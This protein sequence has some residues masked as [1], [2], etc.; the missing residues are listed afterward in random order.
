MLITARAGHGPAHSRGVIGHARST[1]LLSW[2]VRPPL[3]APATFGHLEVPQVTLIDGHPCL[4]FCTYSL[5]PTHGKSPSRIW[6]IPGES[7]TGPWDITAAHPFHDPHLYAPRLVT[8]IDG[9]T[10]LIGFTD[11]VDGAFVGEL[12]DPI[13]VGYTPESGLTRSPAA[14]EAAS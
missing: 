13:P 7:L 5:A 9:T 12:T 2:T 6:T 4:L 8:D 10:A 1:D 11:R 3:T 14:A